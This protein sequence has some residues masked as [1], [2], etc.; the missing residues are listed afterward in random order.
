MTGGFICKVIHRCYSSHELTV[1]WTDLSVA[2]VQCP[3][4]TQI[5]TVEKIGKGVRNTL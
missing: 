3:I 4:I 5:V 1:Q 2:M